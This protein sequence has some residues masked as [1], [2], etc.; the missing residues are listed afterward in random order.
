MI[1]RNILGHAVVRDTARQRVLQERQAAAPSARMCCGPCAAG[2][3]AACLATQPCDCPGCPAA[4][5][6]QPRVE[7]HQPSGLP[8]RGVL[9]ARGRQG[10]L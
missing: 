7:A 1:G 6:Q 3:Y 9:R 10:L 4:R 8:S 2:N 5:T